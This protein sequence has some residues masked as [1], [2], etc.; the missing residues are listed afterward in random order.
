MKNDDPSLWE[1]PSYRASTDDN[2]RRPVGPLSPLGVED[3]GRRNTP[4]PDT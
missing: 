4:G 2:R 3:I 1:P